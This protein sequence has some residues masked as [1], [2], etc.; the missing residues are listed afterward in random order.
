MTGS[1]SIAGVS[2]C[3]SSRAAHDER[4]ERD[5]QRP[6]REQ[7]GVQGGDPEHPVVA[8][9][10][11]QQRIVEEQEAQERQ[12]D[13]AFALPTVVHLGCHGTE[14]AVAVSRLAVVS[15]LEGS[16]PGQ[17]LTTPIGALVT[18]APLVVNAEAR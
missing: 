12:G 17:E 1:A 13:E 4:H 18:R 2:A 9:E 16:V 3:G 14:A 8:A 11:R 10:E 5:Q 15:S 7:V 6:A